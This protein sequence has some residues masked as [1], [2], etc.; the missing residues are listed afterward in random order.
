MSY[1]VTT[2]HWIKAVRGDVT[3]LA[4]GQKLDDKAPRPTLTTAFC[5]LDYVR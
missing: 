4:G 1:V 5:L 2:W 3:F